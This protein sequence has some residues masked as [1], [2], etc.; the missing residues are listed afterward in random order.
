MST[1]KQQAYTL[2]ELQTLFQQKEAELDRV[3][4][5]IKELLADNERLRTA[6]R[7]L[8]AKANTYPAAGSWISTIVWLLEEVDRP[9]QS[10][11]IL[12]LLEVHEPL[13][14]QKANKQKFLSAFLS[15]AVKQGRIEARGIAGH[16]GYFYKLLLW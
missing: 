7:V 12:A 11:E 2:G 4:Q 1:Q 6:S 10:S 16:R 15:L 14:Q 3:Y 8:D 5:Y 13:L 9:L